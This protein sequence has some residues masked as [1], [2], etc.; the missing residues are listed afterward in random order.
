MGLGFV[1]FYGKIVFLFSFS[2]SPLLLSSGYFGV[3]GVKLCVFDDANPALQA[4]PG[5]EILRHTRHSKM[6]FLHDCIN[7]LQGK[8][9]ESWEL[10]NENDVLFLWC[11]MLPFFNAKLDASFFCNLVNYI[12]LW[13]NQFICYYY[14][15]WRTTWLRTFIL[16]HCWFMMP[17]TWLFLISSCMIEFR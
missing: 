16:H 4:P 7:K 14:F 11:R 15:S 1:V 3:L 2:L 9:E 6:T 8:L 12:C 5:K 17:W 10:L 13:E